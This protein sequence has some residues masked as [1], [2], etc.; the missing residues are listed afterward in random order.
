MNCKVWTVCRRALPYGLVNA[1]DHGIA[2]RYMHLRFNIRLFGD[3]I[4]ALREKPYSY[5][6]FVLLLYQDISFLLHFPFLL[7]FPTLQTPQGETFFPGSKQSSHFLCF[8]GDAPTSWELK[9]YWNRSSQAPEQHRENSMSQIRTI[10]HKTLALCSR[11]CFVWLQKE[12]K[13]KNGYFP[14]LPSLFGLCIVT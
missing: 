3:T 4:G 7:I 11:M 5:G 10:T 1:L 6:N 8:S 2:P 12:K 14:K 13:N 9:L